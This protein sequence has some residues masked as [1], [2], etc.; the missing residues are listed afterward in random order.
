MLDVNALGRVLTA[1]AGGIAAVIADLD[2]GTTIMSLQVGL[3]RAFSTAASAAA[4]LFDKFLVTGEAFLLDMAASVVDAV[5]NVVN[6]VG[7]ALEAV[8]SGQLA[9]GLEYIGD[10]VSGAIGDLVANVSAVLDNGLNMLGDMAVAGV[11]KLKAAVAGVIAKWPPLLTLD[12]LMALNPGKLVAAVFDRIGG[13]ADRI[14][15]LNLNAIKKMKDKISGMFG[16]AQAAFAGALAFIDDKLKR[17]FDRLSGLAM[18]DGAKML[19]FASKLAVTKIARIAVRAVV[20]S[21]T[22]MGV[23]NT[24]QRASQAARMAE[25]VANSPN[26]LG[27][28]AAQRMLQGMNRGQIGGAI[29]GL[30]TGLKLAALLGASEDALGV[31]C[32]FQES[33]RS[34]A[35]CLALGSR[36][37][38]NV[39]RQVEGMIATMECRRRSMDDM[40]RE[41]RRLLNV[42]VRSATLMRALFNVTSRM[43]S[44]CSYGSEL[45]GGC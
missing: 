3:A 7:S 28:L 42:N 43:P 30:D 11:A 35:R 45:P 23:L 4:Q 41:A 34:A 31:G 5:S 36:N 24:L 38:V 13:I 44:P 12:G 29:I 40:S 26:A 15:A 18:I 6:L 17:S 10:M 22:A 9:A 21:K 32:A 19:G 25:Y 20:N 37:G 1:S 16:A 2:I 14:M 27:A 39:N 8:F 33:V